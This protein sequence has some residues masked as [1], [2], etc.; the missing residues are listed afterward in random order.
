MVGRPFRRAASGRVIFSEGQE[1]LPEGQKW[2]GGPTGGPRVLGRPSQWAVS[3]WEDLPEGLPTTPGSPRVPP[4]HSRISG[5]DSR[6]QPQ[7]GCGLLAM[8]AEDST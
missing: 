8:A 2:S 3:S 6:P 1:A 4:D 7:R 5:S